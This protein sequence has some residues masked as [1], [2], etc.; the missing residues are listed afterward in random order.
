MT[1]M[2]RS[3][4]KH[5]RNQGESYVDSRGNL[6]PPKQL[7]P[8]LDN[9]RC[10]CK[11]KFD[12]DYRQ[13]LFDTFW[14]LPDYSSKALFICKLINVCEK[15]R[16]RRRSYDGPSRRQFTYKY[17]LNTNEEICLKCFSNT[18][19][20]TQQF[21][22]LVIKKSMSTLVPTDNRGEILCQFCLS[23]LAN[24]VDQIMHHLKTCAYIVRD[25]KKGKYV[26]IQ[27]DYNTPHSSH[28]KRHICTHTFGKSF[29]CTQ[30]G[31]CFKTKDNLSRHIKKL[32]IEKPGNQEYQGAYPFHFLT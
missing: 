10:N 11:H 20:V 26:C 30:C 19:D 17:H 13:S 18:F 2:T 21:I 27:C 23:H 25:G 28:I 15:K 7:K 29:K 24:D 14:N 22:R 31:S 1:L 4:I 5:R 9:C 16:E 8:L 32:H 12:N 6:I 3:E